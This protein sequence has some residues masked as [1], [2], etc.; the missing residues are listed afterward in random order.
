MTATIRTRTFVANLSRLLNDTL[1]ATDLAGQYWVW[2]GLLI[3]WA[4]DAPHSAH[5]SLDVDFC[6]L[7]VVHATFCARRAGA[8]AVGFAPSALTL[9]RDGISFDFIVME[10][11]VWLSAL[12]QFR[13]KTA[14]AQVRRLPH[15][16]ALVPFEL[17]GQH[18]A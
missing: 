17:V 10:R 9:T 1:A 3:G 12:L 16:Q 7:A 2:G 11:V 13:H 5:D 14:D 15:D 6:V 18:L 8:H 4:L